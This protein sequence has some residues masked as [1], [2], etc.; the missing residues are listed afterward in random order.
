MDICNVMTS[1]RFRKV[2]DLLAFISIYDDKRRLRLLT[3]LLR[4]NRQLIEGKVCVEAGSG[5]GLLSAVMAELG[6]KKVYAVEQN[7]HLAAI[8]ENNLRHHH[9]VE[10]IQE[11]IQDWE[12]EEEID[13]LFH[14]FYG[15]LL[16]DEDL[17][18]LER[19]KFT[20]KHVIPDGGTLYLG[21]GFSQRLCDEVV[22]PSILEHLR[23]VLVSGLF[24]EEKL[25]FSI[26]VLRWTWGTGLEH[27]PVE[28]EQLHGDVLAFGVALT[29]HGKEV[30]RAVQCPN[31]SLVWTPRVSDRFRF[32]FEENESSM[33]CYFDWLEK[34]ASE[35]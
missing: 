13:L 1:A 9:N 31:W 20:P 3:A 5:F 7:P 8:A 25:D 21:L 30:A 2:D 14:E 16:Y 10:V 34:E 26:P 6:A 4:R 32:R 15:Q 33:D 23:G 28:I 19:L 29:H 12:P 17:C 11:A 22:R 27:L 18:A 35:K 24:A